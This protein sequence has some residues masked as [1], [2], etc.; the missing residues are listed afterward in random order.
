M[1]EVPDRNGRI[2]AMK[3]WPYLTRAGKIDGAV[4]VLVDVDDLKRAAEDNP[5]RPGPGQR[6]R[7]HR[8]R[9]PSSSSTAELRVEKANRAY[10]DTFHGGAAGDARRAAEAPWAAANGMAPPLRAALE[11]VPATES[12]LEGFEVEHDFPGGLGPRTMAINARCMHGDGGG[13]RLLMAIEDRTD[14]KVEEI[15]RVSILALE[16][17]ARER[18]EA[19]DHLERTSSWPPCPTSCAGR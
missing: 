2:Y 12:P 3:I 11:S 19:A 13:L 4:I 16:H 15:G 1:R 7:G 9:D 18:A 17:A 8:A 10:F 5:A 6:H 14:S